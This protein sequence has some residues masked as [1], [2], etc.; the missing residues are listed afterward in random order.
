MKIEYVRV[1]LVL[2]QLHLD[3]TDFNQETYEIL[4]IHID[5]MKNKREPITMAFAYVQDSERYYLS[6]KE[7]IMLQLILLQKPN[8]IL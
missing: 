1:I 2:T 3:L 5:H 8:P 4:Q 7:K 6:V